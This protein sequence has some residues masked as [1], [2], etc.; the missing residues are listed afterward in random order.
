M[1]RR[2]R[3]IDHFFRRMFVSYVQDQT[4]SRNRS[5]HFARHPILSRSVENGL[6]MDRFC[7]NYNS[8]LTF[9]EEN[10]VFSQPTSR[11]SYHSA[12]G[13]FGSRHATF[14]QRD[15]KTA[16]RAIVSGLKQPVMNQ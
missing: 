14:S 12:E 1:Q 4:V 3:L 10:R 16:F 13:L 7:G 8:R 11:Q 6:A 5:N 15:C 2:N 9:T